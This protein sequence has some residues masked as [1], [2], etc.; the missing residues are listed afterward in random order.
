MGILYMVKLAFIS[1]KTTLFNNCCW[2][3]WLSI[4]KERKPLCHL[5]KNSGQFKELNI[6]NKTIGKIEEYVYNLMLKN[7]SLTKVKDVF[8]LNGQA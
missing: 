5:K 4:W 8:F 3:N 6:K 2:D 7:V 1:E